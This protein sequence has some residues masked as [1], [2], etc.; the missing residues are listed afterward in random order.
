M[1]EWKYKIVKSDNESPNFPSQDGAYAI[2]KVV[3]SGKTWR[4]LY[5]GRG[6]ISERIS[7]HKNGKSRSKCMVELMGATVEVAY[8]LTDSEKKMKNIE[9]TL[10]DHYSKK[11]ELCNKERPAGDTT[12]ID[13]P[14]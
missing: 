2:A 4:T 9:H 6:N 5:V 10:Y 7:H 8:I 13:P 11:R 3:V 14:F 12:D 1:T